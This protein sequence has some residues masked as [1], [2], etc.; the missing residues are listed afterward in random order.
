MAMVVAS[1]EAPLHLQVG[2]DLLLRYPR[3]GR[4]PLRMRGKRKKMN[5]KK[6]KKVKRKKRKKM[7][8]WT[9]KMCLLP[10]PSTRI[11]RLATLPFCQLIL[12][13]V[14]T[15]L[16]VCIKTARAVPSQC[17]LQRRPS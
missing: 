14:V 2:V 3:Q 9:K 4:S 11:A 13:T 6:R 12:R 8:Q 15:V 1:L 7:Y 5:R 16:R 17:W 10:R